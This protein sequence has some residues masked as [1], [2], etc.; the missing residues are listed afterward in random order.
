MLSANYYGV[1]V[2][3]VG[4][5]TGADVTGTVELHLSRRVIL[6]LTLI[7]LLT[8]I[9]LKPSGSSTVHIYTQTIHGT[10]Q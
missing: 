5:G 1:F 10:T 8:A 2:L 9:G 7:H 6:I 4:L 3:L